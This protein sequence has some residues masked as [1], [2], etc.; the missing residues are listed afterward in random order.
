LVHPAWIGCG[1]EDLARLQLVQVVLQRH[2][3]GPTE[4]V[5]ALLRLLSGLQQPNSSIQDPARRSLILALA[6]QH[7]LLDAVLA[8]QLVATAISEP[9]PPVLPL[10]TIIF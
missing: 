6:R 1:R 4:S 2:R 7:G 10:H 8:R 5:D 3:G 9:S